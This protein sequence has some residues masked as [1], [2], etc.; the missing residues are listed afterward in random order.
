MTQKGIWFLVW[1]VAIATSYAQ[2]THPLGPSEPQ[3]TRQQSKHEGFE[4]P[5]RFTLFEFSEGGGG[6]EGGRREPSFDPQPALP[7]PAFDEH[8]ELDLPKNQFWEDRGRRLKE[9]LRSRSIGDIRYFSVDYE[10]LKTVDALSAEDREA[11]EQLMI[12]GLVRASE[13]YLTGAVDE[14]AYRVHDLLPDRWKELFRLGRTTVRLGFSKAQPQQFEPLLRDPKEPIPTTDQNETL[15]T[16]V[17]EIPRLEGRTGILEDWIPGDVALLGNLRN[18]S[19]GWGVAWRPMPDQI[20]LTVRFEQ[21]HS[22]QDGDDTSQLHAVVDLL[23][24]ANPR[25]TSRYHFEA[26]GRYEFDDNLAWFGISFSNF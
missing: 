17:D 20:P 9:Y 23:K 1:Q 22:Y 7:S 5:E 11:F 25:S 24:L 18:K 15:R 4:F 16:L 6:I 26:Y 21:R 8:Q 2:E 13:W 12:R 10:D 19:Y 3:A 14:K